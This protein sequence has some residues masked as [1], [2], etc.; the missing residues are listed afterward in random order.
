MAG[1]SQHAEQDLL[2]RRAQ[3][4]DAQRIASLISQQHETF[5]HQ[6]SV[7]PVRQLVETA[8][9]TLVAEVHGSVVAFASLTDLPAVQG[10]DA[11]VAVQYLQRVQPKL[12]VTVSH[13]CCAQRVWG[14][15][16]GS[17]F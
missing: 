7:L 12:T 1:S 14:G 11:S 6:F 9:L 8:Y 13:A 10:L 3:A 17:S 2:V 4:G 16:G 15:L 5:K